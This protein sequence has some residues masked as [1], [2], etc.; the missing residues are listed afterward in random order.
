VL[1]FLE[2]VTGELVSPLFEKYFFIFLARLGKD[3]HI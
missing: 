3:L 2:S 1:I